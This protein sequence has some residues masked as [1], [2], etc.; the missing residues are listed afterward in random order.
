MLRC[1]PENR[2]SGSSFDERSCGFRAIETACSNGFLREQVSSI[3]QFMN[4]AGMDWHEPPYN[5]PVGLTPVARH[6]LAAPGLAQVQLEPV[7]RV[8]FATAE[9]T[10]ERDKYGRPRV[11]DDVLERMTHVSL[12]E[13][14]GIV[15]GAGYRNKF[16]ATGTSCTPTV[17][18]SG[19]R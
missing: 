10:G 14:W 9:W 15:T 7:E 4:N 18:W 2:C 8:T 1:T 17:A 6:A 13:A 16:E 3:G 12:E 11:P 5:R 19:A